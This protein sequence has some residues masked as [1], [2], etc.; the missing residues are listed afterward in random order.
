LCRPGVSR[1]PSD[2]SG[3]HHAVQRLTSR[4]CGSGTRH[5]SDDRPTA[6]LVTRGVH[7]LAGDPLSGHRN[8]LLPVRR[9]SNG[10]VVILTVHKAESSNSNSAKKLSTSLWKKQNPS[11]GEQGIRR[12]C[13]SLGSPQ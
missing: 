6:H 1:R 7:R 9:S 8:G 4:R 11:S 13:A 10:W 5:R 3:S 2:R 12:K